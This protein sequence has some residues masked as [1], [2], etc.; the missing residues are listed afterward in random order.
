MKKL[1]LGACAVLTMTNVALAQDPHYT[2]YFASPL[3]LNPA[4]TGLTQCDLRLSANYRNQWSSVTSNPYTTAAISYDM[5]A[6]KGKLDNGDAV[7]IGI[8]GFYDECRR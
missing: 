4:L 8:L 6:L 3:T 5:S 2:Q 7:G 1:L